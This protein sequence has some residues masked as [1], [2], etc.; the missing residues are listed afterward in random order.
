L[1]AAVA[2]A[3]AAVAVAVEREGAGALLPRLPDDPV[4]LRRC[5]VARTSAV[6][7]HST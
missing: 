4:A 1:V 7:S 2:V 5:S 3:V 6:S